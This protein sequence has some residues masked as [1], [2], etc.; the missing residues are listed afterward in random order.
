MISPWPAGESSLA[1]LLRQFLQL[2]FV[3]FGLL[4]KEM[5]LIRLIEI[6]FF[7]NIFITDIEVNSEVG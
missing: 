7:L 1:A 4:E 6:F 2:F 5:G 3:T